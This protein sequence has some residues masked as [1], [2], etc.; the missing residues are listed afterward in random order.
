MCA[1]FRHKKAQTNHNLKEMA[2]LKSSQELIDS[3]KVFTKSS[4]LEK[5]ATLPYFSSSPQK[6]DK[7]GAF[8]LNQLNTKKPKYTHFPREEEFVNVLKKPST[9][10]QLQKVKNSS[11]VPQA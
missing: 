11:P 2:L 9:P 3:T 1:F 5:K 6:N 7:N 4:I 8:D 10:H